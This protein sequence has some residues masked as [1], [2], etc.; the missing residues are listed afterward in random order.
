MPEVNAM[1]IADRL[2]LLTAEHAGL[3]A[4]ARAAVAGAQL[5][6][7]DPL[8]YLRHELDRHGQLPPVGAVPMA[9]LSSPGLIAEGRRPA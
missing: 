8:I 1:T 6:E 4:A 7:A 5:G 9:L 2:A 3:L